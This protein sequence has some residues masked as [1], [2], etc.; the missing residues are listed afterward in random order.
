MEDLHTRFAKL[1]AAQGGKVFTD[2]D[3]P[4]NPSSIIK[5]ANATKKPGFEKGVS[6]TR[7]TE[8]KELA[9]DDLELFKDG[10]EP[11]DIKQG[12]LGDCYFLSCLAA[13]A[14]FP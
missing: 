11:A 8:I 9:G 1:V 7:A 10:I 13:L 4:A 6:W 2:N 3:F 5:P 12:S 14:E